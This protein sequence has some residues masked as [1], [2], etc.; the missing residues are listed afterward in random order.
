MLAKARIG[1]VVGI[2]GLILNGLVS[3]FSGI[4]GTILALVAGGIAGFVAARQGKFLSRREGAQVGAV[5]GGIAGGVVLIGQ[6]IGAMMRLLSISSS[7][8]ALIQIT[9]LLLGMAISIFLVI[10]LALLGA[11]IG[12]VI[13]YFVTP[14]QSFTTNPPK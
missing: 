11:G 3:G 14:N 2:I 6:V 4:T 13:G 8:G 12:A 9:S 7:E 10:I 1:F 5:A